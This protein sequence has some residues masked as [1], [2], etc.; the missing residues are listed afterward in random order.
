MAAAE[1]RAEA[2]AEVAVRAEVVARAAA[3]VWAAAAVWVVAGAWDP[4]VRA[5]VRHAERKY[6]T[7][8]VFPA[9]TRN[10]PSAGRT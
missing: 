7:N 4:A 8:R 9:T 3:E 6:R 10:A 2:R 1:V 5:S